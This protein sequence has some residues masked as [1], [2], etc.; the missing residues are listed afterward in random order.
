[1]NRNLLAGL[2]A[3]MIMFSLSPSSAQQSAA[4]DDPAATYNTALSLFRQ[5]Q[6]GAA[7]EAFQKVFDEA[8]D[9]LMKVSAQYHTAVCA[10]ELEHE[11]GEYLLTTFIREHPDN[12]LSRRAYFQLGKFQFGK[13]KYS[14][15][16]ESFEEVEVPDLSRDERVEY[17][18]KKGYSQY[19]TNQS[20]RAKAS[21][22]RVLNTDS[23]YS[24][25]ATY[26]YAV[27]A[28]EEGDDATAREHF[29]KVKDD[30]NFKKSVSLYLAH[31]YHR[32]GDYDRMMAL[33]EPAFEEASGKDKPALAM[34]IG[35]AYYQ[36]E[37][38]PSALPWFQFYERS[39]RRGM[40]REEAYEVAYTYYMNEDYK[41]AISN[42]QQAVGEDDAL[43]QNAYYHL[44]YCYLK[45]DQKKYASSAFASALK[46]DFDS[47]IAED[48]LF[49]YAKLSMEVSSDPYNTAIGALEDFIA[50]YPGSP[51]VEEAYTYLANLYLSTRNYKEALNSVERIKTKSPALREAYQKI[52]FYRGIELFNAGD[53]ESAIT[54]LKKATV[55]NY[56]RAIATEA[57]L[58][59]GEAFYRQGNEWGAIKYYKDFLDAPGAEKV[60]GFS[61]AYYNLGYTYF[62]KKDYGNAIT[63]FGR[64]VNYRGDKDQRLLGDA[65]LRLGDCHFIRKDYSQA[66]SNYNA[67][68]RSAG[69][70]AD[71]AMYQKAITQGASGLFN[72]KVATLNELI[73]SQKNSPYADDAKYELAVTYMLLNNNGNA[74]NWFNRLVKDHPNSPYAIRSMQKSGLIYY[75]E[76]QYDKAITV[77]KQVVEKYPGTPESREA[78]NS[79]RNIYIDQNRVDD[80]YAY[81]E[82]LSFADV[83]VSEQDSITYIAAENLYMENKCQEAIRA[84]DA[85]LSRFP[86]GS[87]ATNAAYYKADCELRSGMKEEALASF[88]L[89]I[90]QPASGF[91]GNSLLQAARLGM[92]LEKFDQA[93]EY[94]AMLAEHTSSADQELEALEGMTDCN[95]A[96]G[97]WAGAITSATMM[98]AS[99]KV[100]DRRI[101][102]A[103]YI[104]AKSYMAMDNL[105]N[106]RLEFGI[107]ANLSEDERGA[108]AKYMVAYIDYHMGKYTEAENGIFELSERFASYDQW[109]AKG[110]LLL[111]D[112]YLATGNVFQ[113]RETLKS[114]IENYRGPDLGA[115]AAQKLE[116]LEAE[117]RP[118][119]PDDTM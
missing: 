49:N 78:L 64:F 109:V 38:Y 27:I 5:E 101:N 73:S 102:K 30:R 56:D 96:L 35:D 108:E 57:T 112:V 77:L 14:K 83:S 50:Q 117:N 82:T 44:A 16:L 71:Y 33:A 95:Y 40:S 87:F 36:S 29:E 54:L 9:E 66:I 81:A 61:T 15:A 62:N 7:A 91:T 42:F 53:M 1:M 55:E 45:T 86:Y 25:Y 97:K 2:T 4:Y 48:A 58:W 10:L 104:I 6:Y 116:K 92:E 76:N 17:Y 111:S 51:R 46:T 23:K 8:D 89:V 34:M 43:S 80:Y 119:N 41:A 39:S 69:G 22:A 85:Y 32:A 18:Y 26:Y 11:D 103:H 110:F 93:L 12:T 65:L 84:L 67:A 98:L 72:D 59:I 24:P 3:I 31:L 79:I 118:Q 107:T 70:S 37:D 99:E 28:F 75:N 47:G 115:I 113:A 13:G 52:C 21:F 114:I 100:D 74:L 19:R 60:E 68:M 106:A 105:E 63:W 90:R 20:S 88:G 94:Y